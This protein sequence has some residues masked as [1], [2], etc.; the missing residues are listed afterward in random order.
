[1]A[2]TRHMNPYRYGDNIGSYTVTVEPTYSISGHVS[3][4]S[5]NPISGVTVSTEIGSSA[6][7]DTSGAYTIPNLVASTYVIRVNDS[8]LAFFP[9]ARVV[10][11]VSDV[12][13]QDF[14]TTTVYGSLAGQVTNQASD[15]GIANARISVGGRVGRT[16]QNGNYTLSN[17]LPG[18]HKIYVTADG[19][20]DYQG[21]VVVDGDTSA[22]R[23]V[24]LLA[25]KTDGFYLPY[26][27]G[28]T[29]KCSQGN[30]GTFSHSGNWYYAFDFLMNTEDTVVAVQAGRV[31]KVVERY[32]DACHEN[33]KLC[34][35]SANYVRIRH[36]DGTDTLYWHLDHNGVLVEKGK[37]IEQGQPIAI[38]DHTGYSQVPHLDFT[39]HKWGEW[40]S[41][42]IA[43]NDVPDNGVP[44]AG[45]SYTSSNYR[46]HSVLSSSV[47]I[48]DSAPPRGS[49]NIQLTGEPT[50]TLELHAADYFTDVTS[51]RLAARVPDLQAASWLSFTTRT[52]WTDPAIFVQFRDAYGNVSKVVSDTIDAIG[53]ES[54]QAEFALHPTV[55]VGKELLVTNQTTPFCE[56]CGWWW[57][58]GDGTA[59]Q[60]AHPQFDYVGQS[61]FVGYSSP[62]IYMVTLTATNAITSS[63]ASHQVEVLA[64][65]NARFTLVQSGNTVL[66][67]AED[68]QARSW[69][70]DFGDGITT[71]GCTASHTY[72]NLDDLDSYLVQLTVEDFNGCI[73]YSY[74]Y[75][76]NPPR[77]LEVDGVTTGLIDKAYT[78]T[79]TV[80]TTATVPL[81]Y[82]WAATGQSTV[83]H[84]EAISDTAVFSW[85]TPGHQS[86]VVTATNSGGTLTAS[87]HVTLF[88][89][90]KA[91]FTAMPIS[92]PAPL[93]VDFINTS[94]GNYT[95][96]LWSFGDGLTSTQDN[97][98]HTYEDVGTYTVTLTVDGPGGR[99]TEVKPTYITVTQHRIYIPL[100]LRNRSGI[101]ELRAR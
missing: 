24:Q 82:T 87:H 93:L 60:Q 72:A 45:H 98:S 31:V 62:G 16:D 47:P 99:D 4:G 79:A 10:P 13:G 6:T 69:I 94:T 18:F 52:H 33:T 91:E 37:Q 66:V 81:T 39:R 80:N 77:V 25:I 28:K 17:I 29:Y 58:F 90:T 95:D 46:T 34:K 32:T 59:S 61:S 42:P 101:Q 68:S 27:G 53:Y 73:E 55:C 86:V 1:M 56:Q 19:Y 30:G 54:L 3:D 97:P 65:P 76:D 88:T 78:F 71:T 2:A 48:T 50:H 67:E 8:D 7:T 51:M 70:W 85:T 26:P 96:N 44:E 23:D 12:I 21:V 41:I 14:S 49:V 100:I 15:F 11:V 89:S 20:E 57:D 36:T 63:R 35:N 43:F 5:D 74:Q 83:S 92:G 64:A 40:S 84:L 75:L 9:S 22:V 38:P